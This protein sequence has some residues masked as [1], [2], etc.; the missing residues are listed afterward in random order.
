M[1]YTGQQEERTSQATN[2]AQYTVSSTQ[3]IRTYA[4]S[5]G[6]NLIVSL[7]EQEKDLERKFT[8]LNQELRAAQSVED[9]RK[10][11]VQREKERLLLEELVT[12]VDKRD[13]LVQHLHNQEIA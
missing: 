13:Q 9:W 2:A 7:S 1:V 11:E 10:T 12:I 8:M 5:T 3:S 4:V 6:L